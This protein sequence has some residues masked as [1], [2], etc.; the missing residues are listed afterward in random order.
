MRG[1]AKS[2]WPTNWPTSIRIDNQER[3][4]TMNNKIK[5]FKNVA[6]GERFYQYSDNKACYEVLK[7]VNKTQAEC[8]EVVGYPTRHLGGGYYYGCNRTVKLYEE[9]LA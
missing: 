2:K 3:N 8:V 1:K 7:K 6:I 9:A 5:L 4:I